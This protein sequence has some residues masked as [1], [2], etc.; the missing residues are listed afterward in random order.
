MQ[1]AYF[2][3][4]FIR[5]LI[6]AHTCV[7]CT[8]ACLD[9]PRSGAAVASSRHLGKSVIRCLQQEI[10]S[11]KKRR[12]E[13][14]AEEQLMQ[15]QREEL[16]REKEREHFQDYFEKEEVFHRQMH[17]KK[18]EI[19][20]EQ[21]REQPIDF[22]VKGLRMLNGERFE[23]VSVLPVPPHEV[24]DCFNKERKAA[25]AQLKLS[26]CVSHTV[27]VRSVLLACV[28]AVCLYP[29]ALFPVCSHVA[30]FCC[31]CVLL[32]QP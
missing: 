17:M 4:I 9:G 28:S 23:K 8:G 25:V 14:E 10:K 7:F 12:E 19:R 6:D 15:A 21:N 26:S 13:R 5:I 24:F 1:A 18:T 16:Q 20:A 2:I 31:F 22:I 30:G 11:V 32:M 27:V 29:G 3:R